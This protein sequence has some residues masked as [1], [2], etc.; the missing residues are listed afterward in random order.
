MATLQLTP[1]AA[2]R[3]Y[4]GPHF[5]RSRSAVENRAILR[6]QIQ[7]LKQSPVM[8]L[9]YVGFIAEAISKIKPG[10]LLPKKR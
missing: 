8:A 4:D 6:S 5:H 1:A 10:D 7:Q 3:L 2:G 9:R